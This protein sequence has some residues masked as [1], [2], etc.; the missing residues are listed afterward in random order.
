MSLNNWYPFYVGDYMRDT[1]HL[2]M[3]EHGAYRLLLDHYYSTGQPLPDD[4]K[5]L[6]RICRAFDEQ[7]QISIDRVLQLFFKHDAKAKIYTQGKVQK[8]IEKKTD[9]SEKRAQAA[10]N[11]GK[12][13]PANAMQ[14]QSK[15]KAND[16][17]STST[18]TILS[19]DN[20][21]RPADVS[22]QV[23][24]D[25]IQHRKNV[26]AKLTK[27][28]LDGIINQAKK[29]GWTLE[30]ALIETCT[31]GWKSFKAEWVQGKKT[32]SNE[33]DEAIARAERRII[34]METQNEQNASFKQLC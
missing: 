24:D 21:I 9:I 28:A 20:I 2:S 11:K 23:W 16:D 5:Q 19:K 10:K 17:T 13:R 18:S 34:E 30:D 14:M 26:K 22:I 25:F 6:Y 15:C 29:A 33:V 4:K 3:L 7:E 31:R 12:N 27:T 1:A 8:E 32:K